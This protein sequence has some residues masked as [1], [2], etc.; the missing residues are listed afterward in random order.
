M[1]YFSTYTQFISLMYSKEISDISF[2]F[3]LCYAI[4]CY[5]FT[6]HKV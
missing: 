6:E 1:N 3:Y 4:F 2:L 5:N